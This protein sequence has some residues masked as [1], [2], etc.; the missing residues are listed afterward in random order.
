[1]L[2]Y[3]KITV[4][5]DNKL[6]ISKIKVIKKVSNKNRNTIL[7]NILYWKKIKVV[8][9]FT[10]GLSDPGK[11]S[12]HSPPADQL[13]LYFSGARLCPPHYNVPR[14]PVPPPPQIFRTFYASAQVSKSSSLQIEW[15]IDSQYSIYVLAYV[16]DFKVIMYFLWSFRFW[17]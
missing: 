11:P 8:Y 9:L 16:H 1:M 7:T 17:R 15:W 14:L 4:C 2:K 12:G 5:L 13:E 3:S 10:T 6:Q